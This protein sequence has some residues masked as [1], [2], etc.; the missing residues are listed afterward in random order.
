M[1][2]AAGQAWRPEAASSAGTVFQVVAGPWICGLVRL[3]PY[4]LASSSRTQQMCVVVRVLC[5]LF[6]DHH[7][8][9]ST[10]CC[11]PVTD[12][13]SCFSLLACG[14]GGDARAMLTQRGG[15]FYLRQAPL[16]LDGSTIQANTCLYGGVSERPH[17]S[18][19]A[20]LRAC[21]TVLPSTRIYT[22]T[23]TRALSLLFCCGLLSWTSVARAHSPGARFMWTVAPP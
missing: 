3:A 12:T 1:R 19:P 4:S 14:G 6:H 7:A 21:V 9:A 18:S 22:D 15:G 13:A 16:I 17:I 8:P 5:S 2:S 10:L 23:C 11:L 20:C